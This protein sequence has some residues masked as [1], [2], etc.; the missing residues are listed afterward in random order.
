MSTVK[1]LRL[2][3]SA[4]L[5]FSITLL[6]SVTGCK[7]SGLDELSDTRN[8]QSDKEVIQPDEPMY[9]LVIGKNSSNSGSWTAKLTKLVSNGAGGYTYTTVGYV[10]TF[11]YPSEVP[12]WYVGM[13]CGSVTIPDIATNGWA[14]MRINTISGNYRA[15]PSVIFRNKTFSPVYIPANASLTLYY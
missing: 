9:P 1:S 12:F 4:I 15:C 14:G 2:S 8:T 3:V 11:H 10:G 7:K 6:F 13:G 5:L